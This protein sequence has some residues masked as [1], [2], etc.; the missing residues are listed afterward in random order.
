LAGALRFDGQ[1]PELVCLL[2]GVNVGGR[3]KLAMAQ[4]RSVCEELGCTDVRTYLQSG[5]VVVRTSTPPTR[6]A[7]ELQSA[8]ESA[9]GFGPPVVVRRR[10]DLERVLADNPYPD[11]D[12]KLLH[13]GFLAAKPTKAALASLD[14]VD[15]AP[16]GFTVVGKEVYLNY[17]NGIGKSKRLARVPFERRLGVPMTARNLNTV[18]ALTTL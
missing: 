18:S 11:T 16:E 5:N 6:L 12:P 14:D 7:G 2:R 15:C 4:L 10:A 9:T 13:V 1:M 8:L 3:S 17:V